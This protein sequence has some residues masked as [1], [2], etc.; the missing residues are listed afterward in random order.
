MLDCLARLSIRAT[1]F[2]LGSKAKTREGRALIERSVA[3]GHRIGNHTYSHTRLGTVDDASAVREI[4]NCE[5]ALSFVSPPVR[6]F[7]PVGGG[8]IGPHLFRRAALEK[9]RRDRYT[10]LLWNSVPG[11]FRDPHGWMPRALE[12]CRRLPWTVLVLH[13]TP[14]GAMTHLEDFLSTLRQHDADFSQEFPQECLLLDQGNDTGHK[15]VVF[16]A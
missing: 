6:L 13:D 3:E 1:F 8:V 9:L 10:C 2:V 5:Q 12:D 4:E 7:R 11:D 16:E 14:T 15:E